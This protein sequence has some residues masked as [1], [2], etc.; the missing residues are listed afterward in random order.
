MRGLNE[1]SGKLFSY[2]DLE[3]HVPAQHPLRAI[4][5]IVNEALADIGAELEAEYSR[6]GRRST[7]PGKPLRA[8]LLLFH[9]IR[10]EQQM[11]ERLDFDLSFRWFIGLGIDDPVWDASTFS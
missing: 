5:K 9:G 8:L 11:M 4:R 3:Q 1:R 2:V 10:S 7:A 6:I